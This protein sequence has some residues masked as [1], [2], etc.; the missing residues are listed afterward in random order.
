MS[1]LRDKYRILAP[2]AE[3]LSDTVILAQ[4]WKKSH[5]YVRRHNW[6]AD[7]LEL[8]CSAVGLD[9]LLDSWSSE[10]KSGEYRTAPV[11]L[12]PAPKNGVWEFGSDKDGGW[13]PRRN[14]DNKTALRPLAHIGIRDQTVATAVM[15]TL[16]DCI[17]S[18]Q[19][20]TFKD[21][22]LAS[23]SRVASYGNRLYCQW[24][25]T[26]K[27]STA[28]FSWGNSDTYSRYFQD[29]QR[30]VERP[31]A[32]AQSLSNR[33]SSSHIYIVKLD[34]SGFYDNIDHARLLACLEKEYETYRRGRSG[35]PEADEGFWDLASR[36]LHFDWASD[37][38]PLQNLLR[39]GEL[40]RGL[41]Q[42]L[43]ASGFF[44]N[45]YLLD[46][47]RAVQQGLGDRGTV[48][49]I[50][51]KVHDY[52]R[53]VDDLRLVVSSESEVD[54]DT[55]GTVVSKWTQV[56]LD[57]AI[58]VGEG[59]SAT[60]TIN[61]GKT[62]VEVFS[63][64]GGQSGV[65]A[66]MKT[67]QHQLSGPFDMAALH[68][69]EGS[70][71]GLLAL[72]E[73]DL[74]ESGE[75]DTKK[76]ELQLATVARPKIEV[77][78]DTLTRFSAYRLTKSLR[79]RR[80]MTDFGKDEVL[81]AGF[82]HEFEVTGRRLV[83]AWARNPSLV[84]VLRYGLDIFPS[85][86]LLEPILDALRQQ[87]GACPRQ[88]H[89][90]LYVIAELLKAGATET[91]WR[92]AKDD[93][94]KPGNIVQYRTLLTRFAVEMTLRPDMPWYVLQQAS[95]FLA[96]QRTKADLPEGKVGLDLHRLL[97]DFVDGANR[98]HTSL[99]SDVIS[100]SLVGHQLLADET[101]YRQW[102]DKFAR[103]R[104][105]EVIAAALEI[106]GQNQPNLFRLLIRAGAKDGKARRLLSPDY[107]RP[108]ATRQP[109]VGNEGLAKG[110]WVSLESVFNAKDNP[111]VQENA[112][113]Q[114][115]RGLATIFTVPD[116][117]PERL[118]PSSIRV[119][120]DDWQRLLD[121]TPVDTR[122]LEVERVVA[123]ENSDPRYRTPEWCDRKLA[124]MYA[125]GRI[126]RSAATGE[127]DFTARQWVLRED[128]GRYTGIR[129]T[130]QKR[131]F[132]MFH[133]ASALG[134]TMS[135]I[136]PWFSELLLR[137]LQWP[138]IRADASLALDFDIVLSP[139]MFVRFIDKRLV[140]QAK[141]FGVSSRLPVY[142]YPVDW[143]LRGG[144]KLRVAMVQG[145]M[146]LVED[147]KKY[148]VLLDKP[149][150]RERHR[151]QTALLINLAYRQLLAHRLASEESA[152][153]KIAVD[154]IIFPEYS[155][156]PADQDLV[157]GLSDATGAMV[158][159][160]LV[161]VQDPSDGKPVNV[162]RWL[163][164]Q[165]RG[166]KRSWI[167]VDQG[168]WNL[169]DSERKLKVKPWRPYQ[170]VIEL[171]D[172]KRDPYRI[173][174]S[175]CYD[176]TDIALAADLRDV[177]H[178]YVVAA[179]NKDV[180]TFD[181][182]VGAL[183]Y[184]MYQHVIVANTGEFGGSTAQAP[185]DQE[186]HRLIAHVHGSHQVAISLFEVDVDHFGPKLLAVPN[187]TKK[188][189]VEAR[190]GKTPPAGLNR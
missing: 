90:A 176:A 54:L 44:A 40:P 34:L 106:L 50:D 173:A 164:P 20:E 64:V 153:A 15:L 67:L 140:G 47:D 2:R 141:L 66:R 83:A 111:F 71:D 60:L 6:Y 68:Q 38:H 49:D 37:D 138:G 108:R 169:T 56:R 190:M 23:A 73:L 130:W 157:R 143:Q 100:V 158:F 43:V 46:F 58:V 186:H 35:L 86:D 101:H 62:E 167:E 152:P 65:A 155:I 105:R 81:K 87:L 1:V 132:G 10:L 96:T 189:K 74:D 11:R 172:E 33:E 168:K 120:C 24:R 61:A 92:D 184:H 59:S 144:T 177:S 183:R 181:S 32:I 79:L 52:C 133:A 156:H 63:A 53:Y 109:Q 113:L 72:A 25:H 178:M 41:P 171:R 102:F 150:Y 128:P 42:G 139:K 145:L 39:D 118:T 28:S 131:R 85:P 137:L 13:G 170:V 161:G 76:Y 75:D 30:F 21:P 78:D 98:D 136:T 77:R 122:R 151:A 8:D 124:W 19:G 188:K 116:V 112:L 180:K 7:T 146:P 4:A 182:M 26:P 48:D 27:R 70:L 80:S 84:Q 129:S 166:G 91:G 179:M 148:G 89:V 88:R 95:V 149:G 36:S 185:Y 114:L 115:A 187:G 121:P 9:A 16:A 82:A 69:L 51:L 162:G 31:G 12:V 125:I 45:A 29:Y 127:V 154:L 119:R 159:Y 93:S 126:L 134:G 142:V 22:H 99:P 165:R 135:P 14:E 160:G 147:F 104:A 110:E 123:N 94:F 103:G 17:E 117:D 55:L 163:V 3:Y 107:L 175:I 5:A 174:G 18:A 97:A 57:R